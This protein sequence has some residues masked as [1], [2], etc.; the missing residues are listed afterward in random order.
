MSNAKIISDKLKKFCSERGFNQAVVG[1]SGGVD[2]AVTL[3][4]AVQALGAENV[5]GLILPRQNVSSNESKNLAE[6]V[7]E[8]FGV[9]V[10]EFEIGELIEKF[11][12]PWEQN[13]LAEINLAPRLRMTALYHFAN[14]QN[15][16]V[17]G[18]SNRSEILLG[19]GTKFGDFAADVEVLGNLFK[20]EVFEL[21]R[22]LEVPAEIIDRPPTAE[23]HAGQTD[24]AE[25]GA[26]YKIIDEILQKLE[27]NNFELPSDSTEFE[28]KIL[29]RVLGN[30]HKTECTPV[31]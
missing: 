9:Q 31:L 18:T 16:L 5:F 8:Q 29:A 19:Y 7:A 6:K 24:A 30:K 12:P 1:L 17:L 3:A 4:L 13:H 23:L 21:A 2:S 22:E 14:S 28:K 15:A 27:K 26:N 11:T 20:T 10:H 25:L